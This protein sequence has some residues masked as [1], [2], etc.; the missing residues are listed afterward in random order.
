M[1]W[2][3]RFVPNLHEWV[4]LVLTLG[5][6]ALVLAGSE[7]IL[8]LRERRTGRRP[9]VGRQLVMLAAT[10]VGIS[11][12]IL[13][14]PLSESLRG[15][16]LGLL[17]I[18]F[19]GVIGFSSTTFVANAMAGL[20]LRAVRNF[21]P[22]DWIRVG[23]EFG[24]VTERGLFHTEIQTEDRDLATLPNLFLVQQP[25]AVVRAS[26]TVVGTNL[27]LGYD[28]DRATIEPLLLAAA[29]S[30]GLANAF[31]HILELGDFAVTYRVAGFLEDVSHL[32]SARSKLRANVLDRLHA[33]NVEIVS[34]TFM[35]QRRIDAAT[36]FI[37]PARAVTAP[38][39]Q[40]P[41]PEELIFDKA[42]QKASLEA[43]RVERER[44][45]GEIV[46]LTKSASEAAGDERK[47]IASQ[48]ERLEL[49]VA[50]I[51]QELLMEDEKEPSD[52]PG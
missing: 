8:R 5:V 26:G 15:R 38:P 49:R 12:V 28:L 31:V 33:A 50:A 45:L 25:V 32:L 22:G 9:T 10:A 51:A 40:A 1:E 13:T 27:S 20:M 24:R 11:A 43:L 52:G 44:L 16:L 2:L 35:N 19:T 17:G 36:R 39:P 7:A 29:E 30:S 23:G 42:D 34:P 47:R 48:L 3:R 46:A 6:V 21:R 18:V 41:P 4:P 37:P 14:L